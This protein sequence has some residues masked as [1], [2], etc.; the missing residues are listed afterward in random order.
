MRDYRDGKVLQ[1][2]AGYHSVRVFELFYFPFSP[3]I[4]KTVKTCEFLQ[5]VVRLILFPLV[6]ILRYDAAIFSWLGINPEISVLLSGILACIL[7]GIV[8]VMLLIVIPLSFLRRYALK[9]RTDS[10]R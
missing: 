6:G 7:I 4:A 8:Y 5:I 2:V 10:Q 1:T 9:K 3:A